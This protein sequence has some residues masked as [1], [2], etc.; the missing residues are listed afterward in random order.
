MNI[1]MKNFQTKI[2]I[3]LLALL[4]SFGAQAADVT[5][6][7]NNGDTLSATQMTE[8]KNAVNSKQNL[9]T[10]ACEIG[11]F[12]REINPDGTVI[13]AVDSVGTEPGSVVIPAV[14][15]APQDETLEYS[16]GVTSN[17]FTSTSVAAGRFVHYLPV[18]LGATITSIEAY[19]F[20]NTSTGHVEADIYSVEGFTT[21]TTIASAVTTDIEVGCSPCTIT[22]PTIS[23]IVNSSA[24]VTNRYSIRLFM[25]EASGSL[26]VYSVKVNYI[27]TP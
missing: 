5:T 1:K 25:S 24:S 19:V 3:F 15:F 16:K 21:S 9:V 27:N 4:I 22:S 11:Q 10:G 14:A 12:I 26:G 17:G 20:D 23:H 7:Y 13:C 6:V 18:P 2:S 8:I